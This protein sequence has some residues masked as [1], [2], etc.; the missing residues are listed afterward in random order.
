MFGVVLI[1][2]LSSNARPP[3]QV[4]DGKCS[5]LLSTARIF[6][7]ARQRAIQHRCLIMTHQGS[8]WH[9][10]LLSLMLPPVRWTY[11]SKQGWKSRYIAMLTAS[12]T[13]LGLFWLDGNNQTHCKKATG[14]H[15][16]ST[17]IMLCLEMFGI[18]GWLV[19]SLDHDT[20]LRVS[21]QKSK[22]W[23]YHLQKFKR[24]LS[25]NCPQQ[26][27][28]PSENAKLLSIKC[29][30]ETF[31][32]IL[33]CPKDARKEWNVLVNS[34]YSISDLYLFIYLLCEMLS[35]YFLKAYN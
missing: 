5:G 20:V 25:G 24:K 32:L 26:T 8:S 27:F 4:R 14:I 18:G 7:V 30:M 31:Q 9:S 17:V 13:A 15:C 10:T 35:F 3:A 28:L 12:K 34:E 33:V 6:T 22:E 29:A 2:D 16:M 1:A 11:V 21:V 19:C 23:K